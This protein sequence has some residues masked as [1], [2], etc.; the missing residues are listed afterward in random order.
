VVRI[1]A[2][3]LLFAG[4]QLWAQQGLNWISER[5]AV[6]RL[7]LDPGTVARSSRAG[8]KIYTVDSTNRVSI[9]SATS[10][11]VEFRGPV[12]LHAPVRDFD[13][14][15]SG[16]VYFLTTDNAVSKWRAQAAGFEFSSTLD[17]VATA[18]GVDAL[19][20]QVFVA[21]SDALW[22]LNGSN[23]EVVLRGTQRVESVVRIRFDE[24]TGI[25]YA[26]GSDYIAGVKSSLDHADVFSAASALPSASRTLAAVYPVGFRID[27]YVQSVLPGGVATF[28]I[29]SL[30]RE[31]TSGVF[32]LAVD[33]P[34]PGTLARN[35]MTVNDAVGFTIQIPANQPPGVYRIV[36]R[37]DN[38]ANGYASAVFIVPFAGATNIPFWGTGKSRDVIVAQ[39]QP[40]PNY[41]IINPPADLQCQTATVAYQG[42][43]PTG[44]FWSLE[45][46]TAQW[47]SARTD[48]NGFA[49]CLPGL[50]RYRTDL[51]L[52]TFNPATA[53]VA[54]AVWA[55]NAVTLEINGTP[56]A[57]E[58]QP[59]AEGEIFRIPR[60]YGIP[61]EALRVGSNSLDFIVRNDAFGVDP[62]NATGLRVEILHATAVP[63][64]APEPPPVGDFW[65]S[66]DP[67]FKFVNGTTAHYTVK[68]NRIG[69][70][71][72]TP[73]LSINMIPPTGY[74][75]TFF[76][77]TLTITRDPNVTTA[78]TTWRF[79][80]LGIFNQTTRSVDV[81]FIQNPYVPVDLP[82][83][84][85][86]VISPGVAAAPNTVDLHYTL[87]T[88]PDPAFPGPQAR[89][90]DEIS[91]PIGPWI[92]NDQFSRWIAPRSDATNS[93]APGI[94][95]YQTS[96]DL[97]LGSA[98]TAAIAL[99]W[100][101]DNDVRVYLNGIEVAGL[102]NL[103]N[104]RRLNESLITN[105]F[106][107]GLNI[108]EFAVNNANISGAS[109]T[110]LRVEVI[111]AQAARNPN[112]VV[113]VRR[114]QT[115][116]GPVPLASGAFS[117]NAPPGVTITANTTNL[118]FTA[119][120]GAAL[121]VFPV[122]ITFNAN[123]ANLDVLV[124]I[125]AR[126]SVPYVVHSTGQADEGT[127][128]PNYRMVQSADRLFVPPNA[129]VILSN[130][131]PVSLGFWTPNTINSRWIAPR[132]DTLEPNA[133]GLYR[134]RTTFDLSGR[135][136]SDAM[137]ALEWAADNRG[138]VELNGIVLD[139]INFERGFQTMRQVSILSGFLPG[140]NTLDFVVIND[141]GPN[142][143][144]PTGLHVNILGAFA[145]STGTSPGPDFTITP[146]PGVR[147]INAGQSTTFDVRVNPNFFFDQF[148]DFS[149]VN[150]PSGFTFTFNPTTSK[151][152]TVLTVT[153]SPQLVKGQYPVRIRGRW[154]DIIREVTVRVDI[155]VGATQ[156][157]VYSTGGASIGS[158]DPNYKLINAAGGELNT[159]VADTFNAD[160]LWGNGRWISPTAIPERSAGGNYRYRTTFDLTGYDP[161]SV[162]IT[163]VWDADD[164]A[165]AYINGTA[166]STL[167]K[168]SLFEAGTLRIDHGFIAGLNQ[169][170]FV[171][172]NTNGTPTGLMVTITSVTANPQ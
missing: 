31:T 2:L 111:G 10:G 149:V 119:G 73:N 146:D 130:T 14:D 134:Y 100:A 77:N 35:V 156:L 20:S 129:Y 22:M 169:L 92:L 140:V 80:V 93:N 125:G 162:V 39:G 42:L 157:V 85:T 152:S 30:Q 8:D 139:E 95:R 90:A 88:S 131:S 7:S 69:G 4:A 11:A 75:A 94:Y 43:S 1:T 163:A 67:P 51:D 109:P 62:R 6:E 144:S 12:A 120:D 107:P 64:T 49:G 59:L 23:G 147:Q 166:V 127:I 150:P 34:L 56:I 38:G 128:D 71:A 47:I 159:Y 97:G 45:G 171:V 113:Q 153:A 98:D 33:S 9:Y 121:G 112:R 168:P 133:P 32:V 79:A 17:G 57:S 44:T 137:L 68:V 82:L 158:V 135:N 18:I 37:L 118:L 74:T 81:A 29:R 40:D 53:N 151:V 105:G 60:I 52:R 24:A 115:V 145:V 104:F 58:P 91:S 102:V 48:G 63:S 76:G 78:P 25:V 117:H 154:G 27:P 26:Q 106:R 13:L 66:V 87:A 172:N 164:G 101:A 50:Y 86:G 122:H 55:D 143:V 65:L 161:N 99:R 138:R 167:V 141:G 103:E 72:G 114:G 170:E 15:D 96:F 54:V 41:Q 116:S 84:S 132:V 46:G 124:V 21:V 3:C 155:L 165:T 83:Y 142:Q 19:G 89:V 36:A 148:V 110:G 160:V 126:N 16:A 136:L 5:D 70:F 108:L 61:R 28:A 123:G